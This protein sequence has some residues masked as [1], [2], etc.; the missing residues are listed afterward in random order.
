MYTPATATHAFTFHVSE[1][2]DGNVF[3]VPVTHL[4]ARRAA[5]PT[6]P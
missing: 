5:G 4:L 6:H 1:G 3:V 2:E